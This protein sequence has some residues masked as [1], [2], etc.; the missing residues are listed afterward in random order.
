[1]ANGV[2]LDDGTVLTA[3]QATWWLGGAEAGALYNESLTY[4]KYPNAAEAM[5]KLTEDQA[6][7]A[8]R[9]GQICFIDTFGSVKV[10]TDIN[11]LVSFTVDKG[12]EFS[13][14]RVMRVLMQFCNDVYEH[15]S[16][17]FI[18]KVDNNDAGRNLLKGW[19]VGYLNE[20]QANNGIRD[21]ASEDVSVAAGNDI[22]SV[23]INIAIRPV[24]SV[25]KIYMTVAVYAN[26]ATE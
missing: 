15:F 24:D 11:T 22:D 20:V 6:E 1:M 13:K 23:V 19:I 21:F 3:E 12:R 26:T 4:A 9:G 5:P 2:I 14:N 16:D 10:C 18:G 17:Y 8:V 7:S 25:E